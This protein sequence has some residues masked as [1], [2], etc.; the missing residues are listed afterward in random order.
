MIETIWINTT[1]L[2]R[3]ELLSK[4]MPFLTN[5]RKEKLGKLKNPAAIRQSA[6]AGI[7]LFSALQTCGLADRL[8][9]IQEGRYGKPFLPD[10][11]F[12]FNLSHSGDMAL[13][14]FGDIPL[15]AD[16][17][18]IRGN[19]P[20]KTA[21]IL[22]ALEEIYLQNQTEREQTAAF[23][24][25]WA[26]KESVIKWDGRGLRLP[27]HSIRIIQNGILADEITFFKK[28]LFLQ[29]YE[30]PGYAVS[31]CAERRSFAKT[32]TE[33]MTKILNKY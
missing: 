33:I 7:L 9:D 15:G 30:L 25:M 10:S 6:G 4:A 1:G 23:Y 8:E 22:S 21:K 26:M 2:D 3:P 13:C 31:I 19:I 14:A 12:F 17:Q 29:R 24:K 32:P 27:M 18:Q 5:Q 20:E 11:S 16:I 28:K